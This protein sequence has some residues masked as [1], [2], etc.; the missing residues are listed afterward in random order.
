MVNVAHYASL[1]GTKSPTK[2]GAH[3]T[4]SN[5]QTHSRRPVPRY[6]V[7]CRKRTGNVCVLWDWILGQRRWV[8]PSVT[9]Y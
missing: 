3:L 6:Y 8:L 5:F 1:I 4:E 7:P 9:L 2:C